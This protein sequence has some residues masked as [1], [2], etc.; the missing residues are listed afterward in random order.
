MYRFTSKPT[1]FPSPYERQQDHDNGIITRI[2]R[3]NPKYNLL[4]FSM[5]IAVNT[6]NKA[7]ISSMKTKTDVGIYLTYLI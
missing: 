4:F 2:W 3:E 7:G 1:Y 6:T 5:V